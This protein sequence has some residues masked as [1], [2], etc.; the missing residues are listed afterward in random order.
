MARDKREKLHSAIVRGVDKC[1]IGLGKL[2]IEELTPAAQ[3]RFSEIWANTLC[4]ECPECFAIP[5]KSRSTLPVTSRDDPWKS[6]KEIIAKWK[7]K[8][9]DAI[10]E[11]DKTQF[12]SKLD[13]LK[14]L[15]P[16]K[17][18]SQPRITNLEKV[19]TKE[20]VVNVHKV[21]SKISKE[22]DKE[23]STFKS[24]KESVDYIIKQWGNKKESQ[25][26]EKDYNEYIKVRNKFFIDFEKTFGSIANDRNITSLMG[27]K[28]SQSL[29]FISLTFARYEVIRKIKG[30]IFDFPTGLKAYEAFLNDKKDV[31][32]TKED[33]TLIISNNTLKEQ[34]KDQILY[35]LGFDIK[36][37]VEFDLKNIDEN[38]YKLLNRIGFST[39]FSDIKNT[40]SS[41]DEIYLTGKLSIDFFRNLTWKDFN[42]KIPVELYKQ[43]PENRELYIRYKYEGKK[44]VPLK[45]SKLQGNNL[46]IP[47]AK[48]IPSKQ[49]SLFGTV[50][51]RD[52]YGREHIECQTFLGATALSPIVQA[53]HAKIVKA[54][55]VTIFYTF[56]TFRTAYGI[57]EIVTGI[58]VT[59]GSGGLATVGGIM[60]FANGVDN[61][62]AGIR[63]MISGKS[64]EAFLEQ[65]V[66]YGVQ[67]MG[68]SEFAGDMTYLGTQVIIP[69]SAITLNKLAKSGKLTNFLKN[70]KNKGIKQLTGQADDIAND[71]ASKGTVITNTNLDD[72]V[73]FNNALKANKINVSEWKRLYGGRRI[74]QVGKFWI[75]E[76]NPN[77]S[78]LAQSFG[79]GDIKAQAIAM[80][81]LREKAADFIFDEGRIIVRD[82]G[83]FDG[84]FFE[85]I[86]IKITGS[87]RLRTPV[88]DIWKRNIGAGGKI[89]DPTMH[90]LMRGTWWVIYTAIPTGTVIGGKMLYDTYTLY[91]LIPDDEKSEKKGV[92]K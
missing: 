44:T 71:V 11:K 85:F 7:D 67:Q 21:E 79:K 19:L 27:D 45:Q 54:A 17:D 52:E 76:V 86:K 31:T 28:I 69:V 57:S 40:G 56:Q 25:I 12:L 81:K 41:K 63:S 8:T 36:V 82:V 1:I 61:A 13:T 34:I 30:T 38:L 80:K 64:T 55:N 91:E 74:T 65:G 24:I 66:K 83:K 16:T 50:I 2:T 88:N 10:T 32:L 92:D 6:V 39:N 20:Q 26:T 84:S 75:K 46:R 73:K 23:H 22:K 58:V 62:A 53:A 14:K 35:R 3:S 89:F 78:K 49:R 9:K 5:A 51:Y 43:I 18:N 77:A 42:G 87:W 4:M 33:V 48:E 47:D 90:P 60:I 59:K 68:G 29:F 37:N 70:A 72:I 15:F